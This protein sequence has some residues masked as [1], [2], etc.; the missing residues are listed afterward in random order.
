MGNTSAAPA[1]ADYS[2]SGESADRPVTSAMGISNPVLAL[3]RADFVGALGSVLGKAVRDHRLV[4]KH[5]RE[6]MRQLRDIARQESDV[7]PAPGDKRFSDPTFQTN[8][9]YHGV[10]Q[11]YLAASDR[12]M[13]IA[14]DTQIEVRT[15]ERAKFA[16]SLVTDALAPTNLLLGNPAALKRA[17]E[18]GGGSLR[19]GWRNYLRDRREN[20]GRPA[21]VDRRP[22]RVGET[23]ALTKGQVV[24]RSEV[25]ELI[26]YGAQ[27][28]EV[29]ERPFLFI[30]PQVNKY[31][32]LDLAPGRSLIEYVVQNGLTTFV[33]SWKNPRKEQRNWNLGTYV[34]ALVE[35]T[36]AI[37]EITG[38]PKLNLMGICA[39]GMTTSLF[40]SHLAAIGDDRVVSATL[41]LAV[42]DMQ[43]PG[44]LGM[45]NSER[46]FEATN[47]KIAAQG[48]MSGDDFSRVF[49]WLRANDMVWAP[50]VS[51]YL[52]GNDPPAW[53]IL[54]WN[55]D[56]TNLP[57]ATHAQMIEIFRLNALA[58]SGAITING[59]PVDLKKVKADIFSIGA[60]TDHL[61]PWD[62]VYRTPALFG[63]KGTFVTANAGHIQV[64]VNPPGNP[65]SRFYT[66]PELT[67]DVQEWMSSAQEN[68]G[69]WWPYWAEWLANRS[70]KKRAAP[71]VE[72]SAKHKPIT[73]APGT[74]TLQNYK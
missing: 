55:N 65:K 5:A 29:H 51:N 39:G 53:D 73:P 24:F 48:M 25:L 15:R 63:G 54:F 66:N 6:F 38:S 44:V 1:R 68:K 26:Q 23:L 13:K 42:L 34:T 18:T 74:Y 52:M 8:S 31:Y 47:K 32:V 50:W 28:A 43:D 69:S 12:L 16:L 70:G 57:A 35:A 72:G 20:G 71:T 19:A 7:A 56:P 37:R 4:E 3:D 21:Q 9:I 36:D 62:K 67:N 59:V 41:P 60:L 27:T 2:E 64:I 17:F 45:F 11:L 58:N 22:Y 33:V 40:L 49:S 61:T 14:D 10:M 30:P 46:A